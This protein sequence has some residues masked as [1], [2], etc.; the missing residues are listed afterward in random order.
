MLNIQ[1][2]NQKTKFFFIFFNFFHLPIFYQKPCQKFKLF[3]K[4]NYLY[5]NTYFMA[6]KLMNERQLGSLIYKMVN[7]SLN[8]LSGYNF[9][10]N[11]SNDDNV[12]N[13][14]SKKRNNRRRQQVEAFFKQPGVN[15]AA[16]AYKL[17][18]VKPVEGDDT[19]DMKNARSKFMKCLNHEKNED[20]YE[21]AFD[22]AE[23]NTLFSMISGN[24]LKENKLRLSESDI[25]YMVNESV[26]RVLNEISTNTLKKAR[27]KAHQERMHTNNYGLMQKRSRQYD[28]FSREINRREKE[29]E[30]SVCPSVPESELRNMPEDTYVVLDGCGR[31]FYWNIIYRYSGHAGTKEQCMEYINRFCD[32][33]A[34]WEFLPE[35]VSLEEYFRNYA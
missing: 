14:D 35:V 15:P 28:T 3:K 34:N 10:S 21:Y 24:E 16:Y 17:Y 7:E 23:V 19:N 13:D 2:K 5:E 22:S 27:E 6:K 30:D 11:D 31:D 25:M 18:R 20:G 9:E 1:T 8:A 33:S 12:Q 32:K 26:K 29:E 4:S